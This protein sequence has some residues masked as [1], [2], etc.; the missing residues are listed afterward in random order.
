MY[1]LMEKCLFEFVS[2]AVL[3]ER[4]GEFDGAGVVA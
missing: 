3:E 4:S 2:S 1:H